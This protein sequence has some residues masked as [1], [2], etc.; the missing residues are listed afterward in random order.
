MLAREGDRRPERF[1]IGVGWFAPSLT[2]PA[3]WGWRHLVLL[4][5]I[6]DGTI[7]GRVPTALLAPVRG[8]WVSYASFLS[9]L[10][11]LVLVVWF[12]GAFAALRPR[13]NPASGL[14]PSMLSPRWVAFSAVLC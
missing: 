8:G 9:A 11:G 2:L 6:I 3:L 1:I 14:R 4:V 12:T 10:S 13:L 7:R 5:R